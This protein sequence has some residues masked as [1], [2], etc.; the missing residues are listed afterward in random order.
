MGRCCPQKTTTVHPTASWSG[1][2][3]VGDLNWGAHFCQFYRTKD[4]RATAMSAAQILAKPVE[5]EALLT[6]IDQHRTSVTRSR[7]D[8]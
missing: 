4:Q 1:I 5:L 6:A 8:E 3:G 7:T 2:H